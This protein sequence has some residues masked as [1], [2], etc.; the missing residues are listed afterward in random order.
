MADNHILQNKIALVTGSGRNIGRAT[1]LRLAS[2]GAAVVV[3]SRTNEKEAQSV[4]DEITQKGGTAIS[5][6]ADIGS[7]SEVNAMFEEIE[8]SLGSVTILVNNAGLR[9]EAQTAEMTT[10][11]WK[12]VLSVNLDGPFY[13][14]RAAI[15]GMMDEGW[16][17]I[18][19]VSGLNAF[20]GKEGWGHVSA[21]KMGALGLTRALSAELASENILVNHI[22]PGPFDTSGNPIPMVSDNIPVGRLGMPEEIAS[23]VD[24]LVSP[25]NG[26][27]TGQTLHVNGGILTY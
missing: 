13:C 4:R 26:F 18:I 17:R 24:F 12:R 9:E 21:S 2:R 25:E 7:E 5:I 1:A 8:K 3:N 23:T 20:K 15:P 27:I 10:E 19:N 6:I 16:G 14:S 22:V 11:E